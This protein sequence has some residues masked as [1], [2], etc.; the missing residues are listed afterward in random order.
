MG[1]KAGSEIAAAGLQG[2]FKSENP[3][4]RLYYMGLKADAER[5]R[6]YDV[7]GDF[8]SAYSYL[9]PSIPELDDIVPLPPAKLPP[10]NGKFKWKEEYEANVPPPL[11]SEAR[12]AEMAKAKGLDPATGRP[13][14]WGSR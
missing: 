7:I 12:I 13:L 9:N 1:V 8:L 6:R 3:N 11:P 14:A 2:G 4:D 10:W 5:S